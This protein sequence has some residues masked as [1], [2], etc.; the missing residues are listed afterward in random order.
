MNV[1]KRQEASIN[2]LLNVLSD[3]KLI[4]T[5]PNRIEIPKFV[6]N[7]FLTQLFV[8]SIEKL[9]IKAKNKLT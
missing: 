1:V 9:S 2:M 6:S 8:N 7:N 3:I 4:D 5:F